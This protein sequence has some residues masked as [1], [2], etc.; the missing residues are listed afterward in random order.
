[1][2]LTRAQQIDTLYGAAQDAGLQ[3]AKG[4]IAWRD[5]LVELNGLKIHYLDWCTAGEPPL[6][7]LH[8]GMQTAHSWDL[9]AV[10]LKRRFHVVAMDLR[11]HGDSDW[12]ERGDYSHHTHASD[13]AGL[14]EHLG[15]DRLAL[16][17][18]S[19]GGLTAMRFASEHADQLVAL[20]VVD[21]GPELN[22]S[23]VGRIINFT[24]GPA[25]LDSVDDFIRRAVEYNPRRKPEQ[26]RYSLTHNLRRLPNGKY[27]WKYDRRIGQRRDST[28]E[29][30]PVQ[31][32]DMWERLR[33]IS[34]P[35]LVV[36]G[37]DSDVFAEETGRRMAETIP[38][39]RFV[40]IPD[41]SHTVPQDNAAGFLEVLQAFLSEA[42][43]PAG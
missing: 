38:D 31:F 18:L 4:E 19:L 25:E 37:A 10:A 17:G 9:T 42:G 13:V 26:L 12:S 29:S 27:A 23:G 11:G 43:L 24:G 2:L 28:G 15:W 22:Q 36:R 5:E 40:T 16:I 1:M 6:L 30:A 32:D 33:S 35:T 21:V 34:C 7:L 8:G 3:V 14:V 39:C 41:A 20:V